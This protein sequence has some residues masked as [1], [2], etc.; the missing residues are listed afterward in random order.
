MGVH[1]SAPGVP[2]WRVFAGDG[3]NNMAADRASGAPGTAAEPLT[4][5][6]RNHEAGVG[7]HLAVDP[8]IPQSGTQHSHASYK[9][10]SKLD[11]PGKES[12]PARHENPGCQRNQ[13]GH[14]QGRCQEAEQ[15]KNDVRRTHL[16][17]LE[18]K[19]VL[20]NQTNFI[21]SAMAVWALGINHTTAPLDLRGRF[22]NAID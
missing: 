18:K 1:S 12:G 5:G 16:G 19:Q 17:G 11:P 22:A 6:H 3:T 7:P 15:V 4:C 9:I 14:G 2:K 8:V 20:A 13:P 10:E 21:I